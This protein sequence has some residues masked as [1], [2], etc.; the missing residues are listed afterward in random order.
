MNAPSIGTSEIE[1]AISFLRLCPRLATAQPG[2]NRNS[3][4][5]K[6]AAERFSGEYVSNAALIAAAKSLGFVVCPLPHSDRACIGV[7][8]PDDWDM[9]RTD[10]ARALGRTVSDPSRI[11]VV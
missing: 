9:D 7:G 10:R 2:H 6:H 1:A 4:V 11:I 3:Y 5:L 8:C